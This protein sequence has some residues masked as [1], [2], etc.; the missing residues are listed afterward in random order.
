MISSLIDIILPVFL[1]IGAGYLA[2]VTKVFK[3][4]AVD[5]LMKYAQTFAVPFCCLSTWR[6]WTLGRCL[7]G[8]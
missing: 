1:V 8:G 2:V 4:D 7:T 6:N 5:H 3:D